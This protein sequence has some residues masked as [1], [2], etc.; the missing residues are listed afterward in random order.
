MMSILL[1]GVLIVLM[2]GGLIGMMI[3]NKKQATNPNAQGLALL[4]LL[5]VVVSGGFFLYNTG[6]LGEIGIGKSETEKIR[7]IETAIYA[8]QGYKVAEHLKKNNMDKEKI[9]I[10]ADEGYEDNS[11]TQALKQM[12]IENGIP[13][14]NIVFD[15]VLEPANVSGPDG[16]PMGP[17]MPV[18]MR[19]SAQ[20]FDKAVKKHSDCNVV[21]TL[22][23]LPMNGPAGVSFIKNKYK[24][25]APKLI[26]LGS[27]MNSE[28][29]KFGLAQGNVTAVVVPRKDANYEVTSLPSSQQDIFDLRYA[30]YTKDNYQQMP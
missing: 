6:W 29:A 5:V 16:R 13:E 2:V 4:L 24:E 27:V 25:G 9:L 12:L 23:G 1:N 19:M 18:M 22:V 21:I 10:L 17:S 3:C 26:M 20:D 7:D 15:L 11:R 28:V 30:F 8:S 14:S